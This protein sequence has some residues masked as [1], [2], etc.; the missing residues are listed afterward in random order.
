MSDGGT[1]REIERQWYLRPDEERTRA[2]VEPFSVDVWHQGL[3]L[4]KCPNTHLQL[5]RNLLGK[6]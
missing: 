3:R 5:V 1:K 6:Y 2:E 4:S